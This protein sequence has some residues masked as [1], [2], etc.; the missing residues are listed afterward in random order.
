M[1]GVFGEAGEV[2]ERDVCRHALS[3][4]AD[5][6]LHRLVRQGVAV[7]E[8]DNAGFSVGVKLPLDRGHLETGI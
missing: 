5:V 7:F 1:L 8:I 3:E 4:D 6:G 2:E